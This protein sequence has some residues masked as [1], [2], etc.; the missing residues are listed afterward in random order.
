MQRPCPYLI[1]AL[2]AAAPAGAQGIISS[3]IMMMAMESG[4]KITLSEAKTPSDCKIAVPLA[5]RPMY[6]D[7]RDTTKH[8]TYEDIR[9]KQ[10]VLYKEC[11]EKVDS[12]S[13]SS[14]E[15]LALSD[16]YRS[17]QLREQSIKAAER[18]TRASTNETDRAKALEAI[19]SA[20]LNGN[21][22]TPDFAVATKYINELDALSAS[23]SKY[24][25]G[26]HLYLA[27]ATKDTAT[28][29]REAELAVAAAKQTPASIRA[30]SSIL[31]EWGRHTYLSPFTAL[32]L[33]HAKTGAKSKATALLDEAEREFPILK[34]RIDGERKS[35][36]LY[37][38]IG[39]PAPTLSATN[40]LNAPAGTTR[41][42]LN[43]VVT[44][45][46][47]TAHW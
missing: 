13:L 15:L 22:S 39:E 30:D 18:A 23:Q 33:F 32:A 31:K 8:V 5:V 43:G 7:V 3:S 44:L 4:K 27:G 46:E 12:P 17:A 36:A 47:F 35:V 11:A 14:A 40:W 1:A 26:A 34:R 9:E 37:F 16:L 38:T 21:D 20:A 29:I 6:D 2:F 24:K 25:V 10:Q 41:L 28:A 42:E 45:V 19:V